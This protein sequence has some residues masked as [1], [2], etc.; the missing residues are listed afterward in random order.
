MYGFGRQAAAPTCLLRPSK[1]SLC[2]ATSLTGSEIRRGTRPDISFLTF[3]L[4]FE[5]L[6]ATHINIAGDEQNDGRNFSGA[7][8]HPDGKNHRSDFLKC[9]INAVRLALFRKRC[10]FLQ[11]QNIKTKS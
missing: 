10:D 8:H 5:Q 6:S 3:S 2:A 4:T 7:R 11:N 1:C 9:G